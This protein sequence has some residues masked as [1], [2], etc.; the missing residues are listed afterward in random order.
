[1]RVNHTQKHLRLTSPDDLLVCLHNAELSI[2]EQD[3][4]EARIGMGDIVLIDPARPYSAHFRSNSKL[5]VF[6][7]PRAFL[8]GRAAPLGVR[9]AIPIRPTAGAAGFISHMLSAIP[10]HV[11]RLDS[12]AR[13]IIQSHVLDL[14]G[15]A[16]AQLSPGG[17]APQSRWLG[18]AR[19]RSEV[20]ARIAD[21]GLSAARVAAGANMS[22]RHANALLAHEGTSLARLI[23]DLQLA[24]V[25]AALNDATMANLSIKEIASRWGLSDMTH[26]GRI[27]KKRFGSS[28][29]DYRKGGPRSG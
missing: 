5:L 22:I 21:P 6:K 3:D 29:R 23:T 15:I 24:R 25:E 8:A 7:V 27:F 26:F 10:Q 9:T 12:N 20:N 14:I 28:P 1:M 11:S 17:H 16:F 2:V 13:T 19:L 18:V 4:R